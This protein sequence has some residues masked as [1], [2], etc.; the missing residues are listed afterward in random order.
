MMQKCNAQ[1]KRDVYDEKERKTK[2]KIRK[3][4]IGELID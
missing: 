1:R 2:G 4:A 3:V